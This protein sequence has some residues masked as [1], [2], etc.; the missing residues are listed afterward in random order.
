MKFTRLQL[1]DNQAT[2]PCYRCASVD[3]IPPAHERPRLVIAA[4]LWTKSHR[5]TNDRASLSL[6]LC[7]P[8][9]TGTRTTAPRYR[10]ASV[11]QIPPAHERP[12]LVI[13][14]PL[15]TKSHRHTNDRAS[16]SLRLCGRN[17]AGTRTTAPRYRCASVDQIPPAHER[18]RLAPLWTKSHR[19][20]NDCALLSLRLC[21]PNPTGTRTTAPRYRR[22]S[23]DQ[24]PPA[25][26]RPRLVIAAP[27][28]TKSHR[29]TN[30]RASYRCA[31]VDQIPPAHERLRL[32]IAAPLWA[33]SHRHTN[34]RA[35]LSLRLCGPN[36]TGTRTTAPRY[37]C[38]SVDQIPPAHERPRLV[39]AASLW[40][41]SHRHT[42]DCALLSLRLCGPNPTGTR[43]TAPR[44][45]CASVD[46]IP[47][48]HERLRLVIAAPLWTKSHRHTNDR[49]SFSLRLCGPNPTGARTTAPCY[50]CASVDQIPPA[51][52]RLRLVIAAPLWTKSH[53]H[54][55]DRASLSLRLCGPNPTGTR[56]TAPRY[57]CTSMDQIPPAHERPRLVIAAPLWNKSHRHTPPSPPS[58]PPPPSQTPPAHG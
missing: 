54:T 28:W 50:R 14:A 57:R 39:I 58:L 56:T 8:N 31:S 40:T 20:T 17:P 43:T 21:G 7:G 32:F 24:I 41:K 23:V 13:A 37:R 16:L 3:Q 48:A 49:A 5:H 22:A 34:D 51:H 42:N 2:A 38:A 46:Q 11:D 45:R 35:S 18:P 44:Y 25:H 15:W 33:K 36:P 19:R 6:R 53:R 30:D 12:R 27:L 9:P 4:P 52:E 10:C 29:H 47:P 55:N 26:E 1:S